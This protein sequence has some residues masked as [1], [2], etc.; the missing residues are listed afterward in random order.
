MNNSCKPVTTTPYKTMSFAIVK[1]AG[2]EN[3][4]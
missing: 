1:V 3:P 4:G 2:K